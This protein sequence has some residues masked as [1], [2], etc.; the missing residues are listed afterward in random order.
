MAFKLP[1][2][3]PFTKK[4]GPET[5]KFDIDNNVATCLDFHRIFHL[6]DALMVGHKPQPK[7]LD[8]MLSK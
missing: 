2:F 7:V 4:A 5:K 8:P 6:L 3:S 1:G